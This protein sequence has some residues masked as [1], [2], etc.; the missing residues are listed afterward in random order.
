M[1]DTLK[2]FGA[3]VRDTRKSNG[4]SQEKLAERSGLD[5][6]YIGSVER[7]ERNISL[8]NIEKISVALGVDMTDLVDFKKS[9][10]LS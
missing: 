7:G 9:E 2:K 3:A 10:K 8:I 4:W 1:E 6:T 5:R